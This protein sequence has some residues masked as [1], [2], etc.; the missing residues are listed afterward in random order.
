MM[1]VTF[2]GHAALLI[3]GNN[4]KALVDPF[5][6]NNPQYTKNEHHITN[7][8]HIFITHGHEDHVGDALSIA[9]RNNA[10]IIVNAELAHIFSTKDATLK[11]HPMHIGGSFQFSFGRVKM[12]HAIHGSSFLDGN[13]LKEAGAPGGFLIEVEGKK[14]CHAGDTGLLYDMKL[15]KDEHID[16]AF[17]PI[18]GN[19]TMDVKDASLAARFIEAKTYIPIHYNTFPLIRANPK[20][21]KKQLQDL[22]VLILHPGK[23]INL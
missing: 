5:L 4:I 21:F 6:T 15:L 9:R 1:K 2:L 8:T 18:G 20:E 11:I 22:N 14:I 13:E 16:L 3:E 7:I 23:S 10:T 17:L 12:T 19:Y